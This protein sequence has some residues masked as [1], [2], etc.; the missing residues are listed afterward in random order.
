[1]T[2]PLPLLYQDQDLVVVDKPADLL[3]HRTALDGDDDAALQRVRDQIGQWLYPVHRLDR[4][5]SGVLV[6]AR[7]PEAAQRLAADF[8][9]QQ[10]SKHYLAIVRGWPPPSGTIDRPLKP[11]RNKAPRV[12]RSRFV[13]LA[14]TALPI[15]VSRFPTARYALVMASP[16]TGR[17]H[18]LRRHLKGIDHPVIGDVGHGD[19]HHNRFFRAHFDS[20]R[21][22]LHAWC[23]A[24]PQPTTRATI[25]VHAPAPASFARLADAF[26]WTLDA[27]TLEAAR[28][29]LPAAGPA[30]TA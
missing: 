7:S 13:R 24:L 20:H 23:L 4:P 17:Y 3:V 10:V 19:R 30:A 14:T 29:A 6:F 9:D 1:M 2:D 11:E 18:Q 27:A 12:S 15:A 25:V 22:L 5:T 8:R 26:G 21:L 16:D 28:T